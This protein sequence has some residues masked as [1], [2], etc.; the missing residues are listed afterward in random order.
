ME[1]GQTN[2]QTVGKAV[3]N[4]ANKTVTITFNVTAFYS[5]KRVALRFDESGSE[6][7]QKHPH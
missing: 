7:L 3:V 1:E 5:N 6:L 2:G 4:T